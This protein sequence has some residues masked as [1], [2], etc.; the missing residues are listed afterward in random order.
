MFEMIFTQQGYTISGDVFTD[1][2]YLLDIITPDIGYDRD[3][4]VASEIPIDFSLL[5]GDYNQLDFVKEIMQRYG[6][7]F[8]KARNTKEY[9]FIKIDDLLTDYANSED[10]SDKYS[11]FTD[12]KYKSNYAQK[13]YFTYTYGDDVIVPEF[14]DGTM[15]V[16]N[17]NLST[18]KTV[19]TSI[20]KATETPRGG[21]SV[22]TVNSLMNYWELS[23]ATY[24]PKSD[25]IRIF[26]LLQRTALLYVRIDFQP[27]ATGEQLIEP[28]TFNQL[29]F[30]ET[31][32]DYSVLIN[33]NYSDFNEI[34]DDYKAITLELNLSLI[35]I[36]NLDFFK[37]KYFKQLGR[38][39]YLNKVSNFKPN[40][41]TKVELVQAVIGGTQTV[42]YTRFDTQLTGDISSLL[43]CSNKIK[44]KD[45][46]HNGVNP[47]PILGDIVY[48][49][50]IGTPLNG[51]DLYYGVREGLPVAFETIKI[52]NSGVVTLVTSCI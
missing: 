23:D 33:N 11:N 38:Y 13:N 6:L 46:Y 42:L 50:S 45:R 29:Y 4:V 47:Y 39:Y 24:V 44:T 32:L 7:I 2:E 16:D 9:E 35:D 18:E 28:F 49:T 1:A 43:A 52:N 14:A 8:R 48:E 20:F 27:D 31:K 10:W 26:R 30:D 22:D 37:L 12:E 19:V 40:Q 5:F 15:N 3:N 25:G 51:G 21:S 41:K 34:L 17:V 36:Y